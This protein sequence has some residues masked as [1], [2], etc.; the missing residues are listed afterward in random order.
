MFKKPASTI[1]KGF[2]CFFGPP[3]NCRICRCKFLAKDPTYK[4]GD[5]TYNWVIPLTTGVICRVYWGE[6]SHLHLEGAI[7]ERVIIHFWKG[8][9]V[10]P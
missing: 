9:P 2:V 8:A 10:V 7:T 4:W 6:I 5:S 3:T 1:D